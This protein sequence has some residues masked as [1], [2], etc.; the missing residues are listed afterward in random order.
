MIKYILILGG[1]CFSMLGLA[2]FLHSLK[3]K[4]LSSG[5]KGVT[6]AV[7][8]LNSDNPDGQIAF[9]A[10]QRIWLGNGYADRIIAVNAGLGEDDD[11]RCREIAE[12]YGVVYCGLDELTEKTAEF[13]PLRE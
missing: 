5:K 1:I 13:L 4:I 6:Y 8:F 11:K 9:A 7:I 10:E 3:A 12:K 2:E